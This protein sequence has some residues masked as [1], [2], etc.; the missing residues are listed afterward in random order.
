MIA[1]GSVSCAHSLLA[2][3]A[4]LAYSPLAQGL[5][6]GKVTPD[7]EYEESDQRRYKDRFKPDNVRKVLAMLE[8]IE[9]I[10]QTHSLS[11][12]QTTMAWTLAQPGCSHVLCGARNPRQAIENCG[13]GEAE[14]S[15]DELA[16]ITA[17]V[18][19]YDGV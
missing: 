11:L 17:A 16:A 2:E 6:T 15:A 7:R 12:A 3:I 9:P 1:L 10:A 13:A 18:N 14:L 19:A 4:M 8:K 5:L